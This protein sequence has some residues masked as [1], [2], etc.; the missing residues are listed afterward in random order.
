MSRTTT[1]RIAKNEAK[2][3][4]AKAAFERWLA[5]G[6]VP[7]SADELAQREREGKTLTDRLQ[8]L[9]I[10]LDLQRAAAKRRP[11]R[12]KAATSALLWPVCERATTQL[13]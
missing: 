9:A 5:A 4:E 11:A 7:A 6:G 10:A 13:R 2:L 8:A 3:Q 12:A 1:R